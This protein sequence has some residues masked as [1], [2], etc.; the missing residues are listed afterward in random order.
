MHPRIPLALATAGT[1]VFAVLLVFVV[2]AGSRQGPEPVAAGTFAGAIRPPAPAQDF[3][4]RDEEG[5]TVQLAALRGTPVVLTFMY[6]TCQNDC[7][8]LAAQ[9]R[10]ALDDLD[11]EVPALAISVDPAND[12]PARARRFLSEQRLTGRMRFL[13]GDNAALQPVWRA[14]GIQPQERGL[15][16]SAYVVVLDRDGV[17]RVGFP[18]DALTPEGLRHDLRL[19]LGE[20]AGAAPGGTV[21]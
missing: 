6:T 19:L 2:A 14:F 16:H 18:N 9:I 8:T 13:L 11:R 20:D 15:E 5:R 7:P 17:A 10:G 21:S 1:L 4:L 3:T 12:T